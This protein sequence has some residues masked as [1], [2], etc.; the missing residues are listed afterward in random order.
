MTTAVAWSPSK[1]SGSQRGKHENLL[2]QKHRPRHDRFRRLVD[3]L[4][5]DAVFDMSDK[6][7]DVTGAAITG[8]VFGLLLY[9]LIIITIIEMFG[10]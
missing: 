9:P 6:Q 5:H 8:F 7:S 4:R 2:D 1:C 10:K 3:G